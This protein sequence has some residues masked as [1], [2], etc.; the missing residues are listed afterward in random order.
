VF[1]SEFI[2]PDDRVVHIG[3]HGVEPEEF[4]DVCLGQSLFRGV[5]SEGPNPVYHV[6]GETEAGRY[7]FCVVI[8]F[9]ENKA[10]PVTAREMTDREKSHYRDWKA[11]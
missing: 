4:E 1:I 7:L 6:L 2:W 5:E 11:R 3:R 9:P 10:Y 8:L